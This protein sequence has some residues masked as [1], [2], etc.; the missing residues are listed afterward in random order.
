[1][2]KNGVALS[3][4]AAVLVTLSTVGCGSS[5]KYYEPNKPAWRGKPLPLSVAVGGRRYHARLDKDASD[6]DYGGPWHLL[7]LV[8]YCLSGRSEW[9]YRLP[10]NSHALPPCP[11]GPQPEMKTVYDELVN[12]RFFDT[13][14]LPPNTYDRCDLILEWDLLS[15][16]NSSWDTT[17]GLGFFGIVLYGFGLP[18]TFHRTTHVTQ[19]SL[20]YP[21]GEPLVEA[22]LR[23]SDRRCSGFFYGWPNIPA[24]EAALFRAK[25]D[26]LMQELA[27][28]FRSL[29]SADIP[30]IQRKA[31]SGYY[32]QCD[33]ELPGLRREIDALDTDD[34]RDARYVAALRDELHDRVSALEILRHTELANDRTAS[35]ALAKA[36]QQKLDLEAA[37]GA[38]QASAMATAAA[39]VV[40]GTLATTASGFAAQQAYGPQQ[41]AQMQMQAVQVNLANAQALMSTPLTL[42]VDTDRMDRLISVFQDISGTPEEVRKEFLRRYRSQVI[43]PL[44][45]IKSRFLGQG[46]N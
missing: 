23:A 27:K 41:A 22:E 45:K 17:Y 2:R 12:S 21:D 8:P 37:T 13:V 20:L 43:T 24:E 25:N 44:A 32:A 29:S 30:R 35:Q 16:A 36:Y 33:P 28:Y 38:A 6:S 34:R 31:R 1:M 42:E 19:Y 14:L 18:I 9:T 7:P 39:G 3:I 46:T 5:P 10:E 15:E 26:V 4:L 40:A 11:R